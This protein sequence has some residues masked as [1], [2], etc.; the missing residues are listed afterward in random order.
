MSGGMSVDQILSQMRVMRQEATQRLAQPASVPPAVSPA[1]GDSFSSLLTKAIGQV[2]DLQQNS[3]QLKTRFELGDP[4][5]DLTQVMLA[6]QKASLGFNATLQV[7]NRLVQA[8]Q[9]IM[10]MPV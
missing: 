4:N 10:N 1:G 3:S 6:S 8:Y 9:D 2:N 5:V 7:R